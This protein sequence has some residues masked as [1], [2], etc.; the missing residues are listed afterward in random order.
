MN[1][2]SVPGTVLCFEDIMVNKT[3]KNSL[4]SWT[5]ISGCEGVGKK[6]VNQSIDKINK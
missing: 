1:V 2:H 4:A 3:A 6:R 5:L